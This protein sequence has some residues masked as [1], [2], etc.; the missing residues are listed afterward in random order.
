MATKT[1]T[2]TIAD[3]AENAFASTTV[4]EYGLENLNE[5]IQ[6]DLDAHNERVQEMLGD[7]AEVSDE[8]STIY[9]TNAEGEMVQADELTRGPTQKVTLGSKVE[10]PLDKFQYGVGWTADYLRR[11]T[12]MDMAKKTIAA[13]AAHVKRIALDIRNALFGSTNFTWVD[14]RVDNNSLAVKRLV[15]ADS[16]AI[17]SGPNGES[18][19]AATH[20]HYDAIDWSAATAD[21]KAQAL[22]DL[23]QDVVEHG[24]GEDVRVY[25]NRAQEASVRALTGFAGLV[26]PNTVI[27]PG[28]TTDRAAGTLDITKADNR[29]IGYFNGFPVYT[30]PWMPANYF[31]AFSA[32]DPRKPLRFRVSKVPGESGLFIAGE[33]ITHP[34]QSR[35]MEAVHGVGV[36]TRTNGAILYLGSGTYAVPSF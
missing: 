36:L 32:G 6:A 28:G 4:Q 7:M 29:L 14:R 30:K 20:T 35:Y 16:A 18:F 31:Y 12:V 1:G 10:F 15:N 3:L 33:I 27:A 23:I 26:Y 13:R 24:H 21:Q 25:I 5:A 17:P 9:G 22:S 34:L 8:R 2:H 19:N 11:A